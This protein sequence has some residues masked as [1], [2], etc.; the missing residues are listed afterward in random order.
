MIV[1]PRR[2][3]IFPTLTSLSTTAFTQWDSPVTLTATGTRFTTFSVL[4]VNGVPKATTYISPTSLS[5]VVQPGL[6]AAGT[7][8]VTVTNFFPVT[9]SAA[10]NITVTAWDFTTPSGLVLLG[11]PNPANVTLN[12]S[13]ASAW[14]DTS[15]QANSLAQAVAINQLPYG[16]AVT[17]LGGLPGFTMGSPNFFN[18]PLIQ[19]LATLSGGTHGVYSHFAVVYLTS[20]ATNNATIVLN[21]CLW[22]DG[23]DGANG[24][25]FKSGS[26]GL[27]EAQAFD[28]VDQLAPSAIALNTLQVISTKLLSASISS[29]VGMGTVTTTS[30]GATG[31]F[32]RN[33]KVGVNF[34]AS[35]YMHG[36]LGHFLFYKNDNGSTH[37]NRIVRKLTYLYTGVYA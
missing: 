31:F 16:A 7:L 32:R 2:G 6:L 14:T 34:N 9:A 18:G 25:Y 1:G 12:G 26:G 36:Y 3:A 5:C 24:V 21:D 23:N 10:V 37:D 22:E 19:N 29:R 8:P 30:I 35:A 4:N 15:G 13:N 28:T 20:I 17:Q 33:I 27:V 11:D